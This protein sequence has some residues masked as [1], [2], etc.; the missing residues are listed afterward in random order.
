MTSLN[1][2]RYQKYDQFMVT[3]YALV[4]QCEN[5][6]QILIYFSHTISMTSIYHDYCVRHY[7]ECDGYFSVTKTPAKSL[8]KPFFLAQIYINYNL[9]TLLYIDVW[10]CGLCHANH[11]PSYHLGYRGSMCYLGACLPRG[12]VG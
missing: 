4:P 8:G 2:I 1:C 10:P 12:I 7:I 6:S 11:R 5:S 3:I 9:H